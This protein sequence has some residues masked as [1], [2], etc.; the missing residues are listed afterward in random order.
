MFNA[1]SSE[2][3]SKNIYDPRTWPYPYLQKD[4]TVHQSGWCPA[5]N[6]ITG[7]VY[8]EVSYIEL[9]CKVAILPHRG[10]FSLD[11]TPPIWKTGMLTNF[12]NLLWVKAP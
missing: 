11:P 5:F 7:Q 1:S 12:Y 3:D 6:K 8:L 10:S 2:E 4:P 9:L